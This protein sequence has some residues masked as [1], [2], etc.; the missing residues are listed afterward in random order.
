MSGVDPEVLLRDFAVVFQDVLLFDDTVMGNIRLGRRGATDEEVLAAAQAAKC[1][2]FVHQLAAGLSDHDRRER[3]PGSRAASASASPSPAPCLKDAPIV[4]LDEA[5]ASPRRGERDAG[6]AGALA[7]ARGQ[8]RHRDR[9]PHAHRH[10]APTRSWCSTAAAWPS[11]EPPSSLW[12]EGGLFAR[13]VRLQ[14][15]SAEWAI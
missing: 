2:E 1:D 11:R 9:P 5:T 4:L 12:P 13:M 15:E 3:Q 8:D 6:P 10:G 14:T 7:P